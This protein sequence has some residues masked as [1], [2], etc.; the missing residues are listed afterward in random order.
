[1]P[2][3]G[4][5]IEG[6]HVRAV[7]A[8]GSARRPEQAGGHVEQRGLAG[9][10]RPDQAGDPADRSG[11]ADVVDRDMPAVPDRDLG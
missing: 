7:Q 4:G 6:G 8:Q 10:V 1:M 9:A 11:Q 5:R 2:G 3:P